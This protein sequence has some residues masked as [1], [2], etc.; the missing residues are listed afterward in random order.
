[1]GL[2][3]V[4]T[5]FTLRS[6]WPDSKHPE[7]RPTETSILSRFRDSR[8]IAV[9]KASQDRRIANFNSDQIAGLRWS[10][11]AKILALTREHD[12][13]DVAVLRDTTE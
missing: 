13:S 10:T 8:H 12:D 4:Y 2:R 1:M 11:D 7:K 3:L 5:E 6:R 9:T